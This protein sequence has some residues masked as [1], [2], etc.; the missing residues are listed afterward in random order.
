MNSADPEPGH[1]VHPTARNG[2][3]THRTIPKARSLTIAARGYKASK[4][5]QDHL[6]HA[7][8]RVQSATQEFRCVNRGTEQAS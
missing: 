6:P 4:I 7:R 5:L 2:P 8:Q 3:I 1:G